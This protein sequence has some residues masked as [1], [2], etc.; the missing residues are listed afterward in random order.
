MAASVLA[1]GMDYPT[2][3]QRIEEKRQAFATAYAQSDSAQRH[4]LIDSARTYLFDRITL[5][6]LPAWHGTAWDFNG[7]TRVPR[8]GKIACGYFVNT[9]LQDAGFRLPRIKW[10]QMAAEPITVK[11]SH[12]I[13]RFRDRPVNDVAAYIQA[14]GDGLYK[15][16]LD[17]HVGF[18]VCRNGVV[19]FVHSNY[20]QREVGVMSEPLDGNNPLAHSHYRIIGGLLGDEMMKAWIR[21]ADL[22][23]AP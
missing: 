22:D 13:A 3:K 16:G 9:V 4:H 12:T 7:T 17:N 23:K 20:Y 6:I 11:L 1:A 14:Q 15:V 10:S 2:L 18:I 21:G 8:T 5:D 19:R